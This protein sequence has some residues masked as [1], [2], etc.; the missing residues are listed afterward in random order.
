MAAN[1]SATMDDSDKVRQFY[2][3]AVANGI[4][5]LP[6][7]VNASEYRFVPVDARTIRYGLGAVKGT[8]RSATEAIVAARQGSPFTDFV[9]FCRRVDKRAVNRRA[10]EAL[11]R[12]GA[13]DALEPNRARLIA[14]V[15]P[16]L[17]LADQEARAALQVNLFGDASGVASVE[18]VAA[19]P[20]S[21]LE[22]LRHEKTALGFYFSGHPYNTYRRELEGLIKLPLARLTANKGV[23][24]AGLI[25]AVRTQITRRGKMCFV[26]LDD[27]TAQV[28]VSVFNELFESG[29]QKLKEDQVLIV[30]GK[31]S[32]D[33][34]TGGLRVVADRLLD[35]AAVRAA[36]A[37]ELRLS[38]NGGS[39][40]ERLGALLR[41]HVNGPTAVTL[42]Y[43]CGSAR[44]ELELGEAWKV[45]LDE[46]LLSE[47]REW[48]S[49]ENVGIVWD[50][51]PPPAPPRERYSANASSSYAYAE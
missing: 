8:G 28:E 51:P 25:T 37:R 44:G 17:D 9:D 48:L 50:P 15:G 39:D 32:E 6:P 47:L 49:T 14:S 26:S 31:V 46:R 35:L 11:I 45:S 18:L 38:C 21:E 20:W 7:D 40:A 30:E 3:D 29:R 4:A 24:I 36:Y 13:F 16:V 12:G 33:G 41:P 22:R 34:F 42:V 27:G 23:L 10:I 5:F 43:Q 1:L 19:K 2:E